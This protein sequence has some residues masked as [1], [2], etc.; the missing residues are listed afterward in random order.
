MYVIVW[1]V[2][3]LA[4]CFFEAY[5]WFRYVMCRQRANLTERWGRKISGLTVLFLV[6]TVPKVAGL[7]GALP[8]VDTTCLVVRALDRRKSYE[9][10]S[11]FI[12]V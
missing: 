6:N 4:F 3:F 10:F 8:Y 12:S 5:D 9:R 1:L 7:H 2:N 11:R